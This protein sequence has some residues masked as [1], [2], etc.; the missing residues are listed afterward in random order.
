MSN[1]VPRIVRLLPEPLP[2]GEQVLWRGAPSKWSFALRV[3]RIREVAIGLAAILIWRAVASY[4]ADQSV[5]AA[6]ITVLWLLPLA[7]V[8]L[9]LLGLFAYLI[10]RTT[11]YLITGRRLVMRY[12]VVAPMTLNIPFKVIGSAALKTY[13]DGTGDIPVVTTGK[14]QVAF[15]ML[16]PHARPWHIKR[17]E[18]ML[19]VVPNADHVAGILSRAMAA[20]AEAAE[21]P[22]K[23]TELADDAAPEASPRAFKAA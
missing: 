2:A 17:P 12:G 10:G 19:R 15:Y 13:P 14:D 1:K 22:S 21:A 4:A 7:L 5:A 6:A 18:P 9:G 3:F 23:K 11:T 16:W 8:T 20:A